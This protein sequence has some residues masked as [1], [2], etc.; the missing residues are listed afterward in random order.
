[1]SNLFFFR[2]LF[3]LELILAEAMFLSK[4][5]IRN[6]FIIRLII[7]LLF[8]FGISFI[9]PTNFENI[10]YYSF[11]FLIMFLVTIIASMFCFKA[12]LKNILFCA[13]A[14]YT[15]QHI[16]SECYEMF[17]N[18]MNLIIERSFNFYDAEGT[19]DIN[20][21]NYF[22]LLVYFAIFVIIYG[23]VYYLIVPKVEKY[24]VLQT[25]NKVILSLSI[26][27][28]LI[29]VIIGAIIL[30]ILPEKYLASLSKLVK[31]SVYFLLHFYNILCCVLA[32]VLLIELPRRSSAESDLITVNKL[33]KI[34]QSQYN[35]VKENLDLINIKCRDL[36][37]QM[38]NILNNKQ[39][40]TS[41]INKIEQ[42]I[43]IYDSTY[44]TKNE[45]LNIVLMEKGLICKKN[46]IELT[47]I[48]DASKLSF[49]KDNDIYSLFGNLL[50]NA[51][52]AVKNL[53]QSKRVISLQIKNSGEFLIIKTYNNYNG[54]INFVNNLPI[55]TKEDKDYHGYGLKSINY[56]VKSYDGQMKIKTNNQVF[57]LT[58]L[59]Q[60][61]K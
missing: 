18:Y 2:P 31:F 10:Y 17:N 52:E 41:E 9:L 25:N 50:D 53:E 40:D 29:D 39:V 7:S 47:C 48:I 3:M 30:F 38:R 1:M 43:D 35:S 58:I 36:K 61:N 44:K 5:N 55:T 13:I 49:I 37:H 46:K 28:V 56:I 12:P 51:I 6:N 21:Q 60:T 8:C 24:K 27:I 19:I 34:E 20:A 33:Y 11:L 26:F 54:K 14:G 15:I 57:D 32:I 16:A 4:L 22:F 45:A 59:F 42:A 23:L